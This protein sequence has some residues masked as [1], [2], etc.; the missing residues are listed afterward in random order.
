M[1]YVY[2]ILMLSL[3]SIMMAQE[4][5]N[6]ESVIQPPMEFTQKLP[7]TISVQNQREYEN[8]PAMI[9]AEKTQIINALNERNFPSTHIIAAIA[10][11]IAIALIRGLPETQKELQDDALAAVR[12]QK[13]SLEELQKV[14]INTPKTDETADAFFLRLDSALRKYLDSTYH[15][16][17]TTSTSQELSKSAESIPGIDP[18][19]R[20]QLIQVLQK[21]DQVKFA[22]Q[23]ATQ[24]DT[25]MAASVVKSALGAI[26]SLGN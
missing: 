2:L 6:P 25:E 8:N 9:A 3:T 13:E 1:R 11:L 5:F 23:N 12:K 19:I 16:G 10:V 18:Q 20:K 14:L 4:A 21:T 7:V 15:I 24:K 26:K 22:R 17:A